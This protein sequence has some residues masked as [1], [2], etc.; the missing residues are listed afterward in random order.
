MNFV[1]NTI[2]GKCSK[3][4]SCCGSLLPLTEKDIKRIKYI[5]KAKKL[6]Q[7]RPAVA[8]AMVIDLVCPFLTLDNKCSIYKDRPTICRLFKCDK[9]CGKIDKNEQAELKGAIPYNMRDFFKEGL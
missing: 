3:C 2:N 1:N 4:A 8:A 5:V 7:C 9:E 6:K